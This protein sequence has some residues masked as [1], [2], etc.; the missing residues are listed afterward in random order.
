MRFGYKSQW[1]GADAIKQNTSVVA[2]R[3]LLS[4]SRRRKVQHWR[5]HSLLLAVIA[6]REITGESLP[7]TDRRCPLLRRACC[8][9]G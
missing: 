1:F 7:A 4:L 9:E 3:L 5:L 6:K 8:T 2:Q